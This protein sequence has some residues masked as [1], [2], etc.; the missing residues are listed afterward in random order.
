M[1]LKPLTGIRKGFSFL[2]HRFVNDKA[3]TSILL[4]LAQPTGKVIGGNIR[5]GRFGLF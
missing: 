5:F 4:V 3:K 1:L 2:D